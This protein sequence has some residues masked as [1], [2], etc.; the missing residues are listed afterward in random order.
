MLSS[1]NN[2]GQKWIF[3]QHSMAEALYTSMQRIQW[4]NPHQV[5]LNILRQASIGYKLKFHPE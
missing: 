1:S 5:K 3:I 2:Y 4:A